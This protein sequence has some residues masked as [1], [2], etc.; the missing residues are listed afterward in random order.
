MPAK[1]PPALRSVT[2][3]L[4]EK[5]KEKEEEQKVPA[6]ENSSNSQLDRPTAKMSYDFKFSISKP[7][8]KVTK[9]RD[10]IDLFSLEIHVNTRA[11]F[12]PDFD[13]DPVQMAFWCL[14]TEDDSIVSNGFQQGYH[15][16]IIAVS[17]M[18]P[19]SLGFHNV[20]VELV[21]SEKDLL[22]ALIDRVR[23][24]DPDLLVGYELHSASWGYLIERAATYD[25]NLIDELSRVYTTSQNIQR[26]R[27]GYQKASVFRVI[28]RHMINV[29]RLMK[30]EVNLK[31]YTYEN[32]VYNLLHYRVPHFSHQILTA[33]YQHGA[34]VV[35]HRLVRYYLERVQINLDLLDISEVISR[36]AE[37]ARV[38]GIDFY[39]VIT[40][41]SQFKVE[42]TMLRIAKPENYMLISPSRKQVAEQRAIECLPLIMEP[43]S[44]FYASPL[45]VLD[46]QSLYPSIMIAYNYC[47]STCLGRVR[48]SGDSR[49]F[50]VSDLMISPK[51]LE[52]LK[53]QIN[54]A[55]NG[56]M[57]VKESI[58]KSL[59][60]KMLT[61]L[62][63]TRVMVKRSMKDYKEDRGL[64]RLLNARQLT[65]KY[66]ANVTYGYTSAT[67]SG[68]MP[69][70]DIADSIVQTGREMLEKT[71]ELVNS[72]ERWG[73]KVVYGDTD[74][75]FVYFP[76]KTR[77]DAFTIGNEIAQTITKMFPA[78]IKLK[79]EKVYH[80][81]V[82]VAKKRYVGFKY[83]SPE[84]KE[85]AFE[86]KGI[87][88]VR[89]DGVVATQKIQ[90]SSLKILFR[91]QDMCELKQYLYR[92]WTK[93]LSNRVSLQDFIIAKEVRLGTY[94][95]IPHGA[96]VAQD[97]MAMDPRAEPQYGE[98][99]PYVVVY[100]GANATLKEKVVRPEAVL[101]DNS[102]RLDAEYYIRKQIIPPLERIFNLVGVD[103]MAWYDSMPRSQK[104]AALA[105][106]YYDE[107]QDK[108]VNRIDRYYASS[109]CIICRQLSDQPIC[110]KCKHQ[111]SLSLLTLIS[112]QRET[113][114]KLGAVLEVCDN[115][116]QISPLLTASTNPHAAIGRSGYADHPCDSLDCPVFYERIKAK[117]DVRATST[118]DTLLEQLSD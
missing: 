69:A 50:G 61:E 87:E 109:H 107:V 55:P 75:V 9:I 45:V 31:S 105:L 73:A 25:I 37:S 16:G 34:A 20:D 51:L 90:E 80:P 84:D 111:K 100:R 64:L 113:Q 118:Y 114:E 72:T 79:F 41:G 3:W 4:E 67:F 98:R 17:G 85:P 99:V 33:W 11:N 110:D 12:L 58:R 62:L 28:G 115:C 117:N 57:Y 10:Y 97:N 36:T 112:R 27:W 71:I 24:Y 53:E 35:K 116:S 86:A 78:P 68:R 8:A 42:S 23:L 19:H 46:F 65:L 14:Q 76:G 43:L 18:D 81:S 91:T 104:A 49:K 63:D 66:L 29:W 39:S 13:R 102:L 83:E 82:L 5:E 40:R 48:R 108:G 52:E 7:K 1:D 47:Y 21:D 70:V 32:V 95:S 101:L 22:H 88:T 96:K 106:S 26:D 94:R 92:E 6:V 103:I 56:V 2:R 77:D 74:S 93:I 60:A 89:R 59:L 30:S 15:I 38:F 54:V 44:K